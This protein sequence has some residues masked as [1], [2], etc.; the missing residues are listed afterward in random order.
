MQPLPAEF[1]EVL[2]GQDEVLVTSR[3]GNTHGTVPT[4][5]VIA[6]P[7]VVYLFTFSFSEKARRFRSDPWVRLTTRDGQRVSAEGVAH[8]VSA[9]A[10]DDA[11]AEL[12]VERW[13]MQGAPTL[14]GLR[15]T[16]RDRVHALIRVEG[17]AICA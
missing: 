5:F 3:E 11:T 1:L 2:A 17:Q 7:G 4:W 6:P 9:D 10:L 13:S 16:L 14:P 15:R 8:F 12:V